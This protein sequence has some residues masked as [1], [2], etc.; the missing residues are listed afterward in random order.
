VRTWAQDCW[1]D[2]DAERELAGEIQW[3]AYD[4]PA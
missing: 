4:L 2:L 3:R 1:G